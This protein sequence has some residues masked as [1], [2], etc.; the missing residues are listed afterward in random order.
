MIV[1]LNQIQLNVLLSGGSKGLVTGSG[2]CLLDSVPL[3]TLCHMECL[4]ITAL[5]PFG[6]YTFTQLPERAYNTLQ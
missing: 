3:K 1:L 2:P 4:S 6:Q 5:K